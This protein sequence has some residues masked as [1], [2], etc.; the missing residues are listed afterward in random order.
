MEKRL[1]LF[2]RAKNISQ[3]KF[4]DSINV[5]KASVS[6]ILA[7]RNKP[8][9]EFIENMARQY[10]E[11][12]IEW[13]VTGKGEMFKNNRG[14]ENPLSP[15]VPPRETRKSDSRELEIFPDEDYS[16][17]NQ[18]DAL[19]SPQPVRPTPRI[20]KILVFYD[21]GTFKEIG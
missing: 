15:S 14:S 3:S 12:N 19:P 9:F 17:E 1:D 20:S 2:L 8:G 4:A 11:L 21:N 6:H 5:A 13:F 7:G 16:D 10:P 18:E